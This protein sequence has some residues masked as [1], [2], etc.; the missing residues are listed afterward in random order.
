MN[1]QAKPAETANRETG[2]IT[3]YPAILQGSEQSL[4]VQLAMAELNQDV[5]TARSFP[6]SVATVMRNITQL[7]MLD[8]QTAKECVYAVPR[9]GKTIRGPSIRL[10]EI[11]ASQWG[12]CHCASRVVHVDRIEKYVESEGVFHDLETGL[13]RTARTRKPIAKRDGG[14]YSLDM[15]M[16]AGNAAAS[17]GMR[18]A[19]L[20]GVPKAVWRQAYDHAEKVIRGDVTTLVERRDDAL[21]ALAGIGVTPDRVFAAVGV[22]GI[23]E[24]GLDELAN[25]FAMF[26]GVK[27]GETNV[28]DIFPVVRPKGDQPAGLKGKLEQLAGD[29]TQEKKPAA[30]PKGDAAKKSE[31]GS[32]P[33]GSDG[34]QGSTPA[35]P[36]AQP[37]SGQNPS[38]DPDDGDPIAGA[39]R[40]GAEAR[41]KGMSR[42]ALPADCRKDD[43]MRDAWL[44]GFDTGTAEREPGEEG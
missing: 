1:T 17:I 30:E 44:D 29:G 13:K 34:G 4:A 2:E 8:E 25:L 5:V 39:C 33:A 38:Q 16:T 27:N 22:A 35:N 28:D 3:N 10:A 24:I 6:R 42:K 12:N 20:K 36:A 21:K 14:V 32:S 19:I 37:S 43:A 40:R 26:Q 11:I 15:V 9:D 7:V 41:H 23:E 31:P 18:E